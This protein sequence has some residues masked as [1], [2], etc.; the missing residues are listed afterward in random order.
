MKKYRVVPTFGI[1]TIFSPLFGFNDTNVFIRMPQ[2]KWPRDIAGDFDE[3][4]IDQ[5]ATEFISRFP[6]SGLTARYFLMIRYEE[7]L[8]RCAE[9]GWELVDSAEQ[10]GESNQNMIVFTFAKEIH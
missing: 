7:F 5:K 8:N 1:Q 9:N 6:I 4:L 10:P 3:S 2:G